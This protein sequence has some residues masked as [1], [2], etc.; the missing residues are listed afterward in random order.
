MPERG[1]F[2]QRLRP[3]SPLFACVLGGCDACIKLI[4]ALTDA[5]CRLVQLR[6]CGL[7]QFPLNNLPVR[8]TEGMIA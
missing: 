1:T 8:G 3:A 4:P 5:A 2:T 6:L 7:L